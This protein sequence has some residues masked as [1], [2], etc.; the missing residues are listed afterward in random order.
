MGIQCAHKVTITR[1][2]REM[3]QKTKSMVAIIYI[4]GKG[5]HRVGGR[6]SAS[7]YG[8]DG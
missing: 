7:Q 4:E 5:K 8:G 6:I 2:S 1:V 3:E